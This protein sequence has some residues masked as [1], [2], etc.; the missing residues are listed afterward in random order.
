MLCKKWKRFHSTLV[1]VSQFATQSQ[2]ACNACEH[3]KIAH[4]ARDVQYGQVNLTWSYPDQ[5]VLS[6]Q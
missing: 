2:S 4:A 6:T 3:W 1:M 5:L